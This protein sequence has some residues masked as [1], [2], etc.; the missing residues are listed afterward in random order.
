MKKILKVFILFLI[1]LS[2]NTCTSGFLGVPDAFRG[3]YQSNNPIL[4]EETYLLIYVATG[5]FT[6]YLSDNGDTNIT[7]NNRKEYASISPYNIVGLDYN[8]TFETGSMNGA[9][10]FNGTDGADVRISQY[11]PPF[12]I[13]TY[14]KKVS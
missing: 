14:C 2:L 12:T 13:K 11:N 9:V 8:Y 4:D 5:S 3:Y 10:N 6:I 7:S 1:A